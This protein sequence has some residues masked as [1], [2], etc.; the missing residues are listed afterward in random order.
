MSDTQA[1][2]IMQAAILKALKAEHD[3][4]RAEVATELDPGD[5]KAPRIDGVKIGTVTMS[6]PDP[7]AV[8][9]DQA[10]LTSWIH[11]HRP[12]LVRER[13]VRIN[14][15]RMAEA[16][17][18]LEQ[19]APDLLLPD[20]YEVPEWALAQAVR[21]AMGDGLV[22]DGV[23]FRAKSP[24]LSV[25]PGKDAGPLVQRMLETSGLTEIGAG[26]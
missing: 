26:A 3:R 5:K 19:H 4:L 18:V 15:D 14:P 25:R 12:D 11:E 16:V 7:E 1:R 10:A 6:D 17:K 24:V 21:E 8:V 20:A 13:P 9:T 23:D 2:L 22:P